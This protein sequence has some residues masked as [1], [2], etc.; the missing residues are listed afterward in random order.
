MSTIIKYHS[1]NLEDG[2]E[3][4]LMVVVSGGG[5]VMT[6]TTTITISIYVA[7]CW[8]FFSLLILK[9]RFVPRWTKL[10]VLVTV[11]RSHPN[12]NRHSYT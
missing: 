1:M 4:K 8:C 11:T 9:V 2:P 3:R 12:Q 5:G 10:K 6:I 7:D